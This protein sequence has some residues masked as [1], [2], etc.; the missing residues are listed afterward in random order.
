MQGPASRHVLLFESGHG[1]LPRFQIERAIWDWPGSA[2]GRAGR[3]DRQGAREEKRE[4]KAGDEES[5]PECRQEKRDT[6]QDSRGNDDRKDDEGKDDSGKDDGGYLTVLCLSLPPM[7]FAGHLDRSHHGTTSPRR[8]HRHVDRS[9]AAVGLHEVCDR[10]V[11]DSGL[12][13][14]REDAL[15]GIQ[16][17][18]VAPVEDRK[19]MRAIARDLLD[20]QPVGA[21]HGHAASLAKLDLLAR[22]LHDVVAVAEGEAEGLEPR[23]VLRHGAEQPGRPALG[24]VDCL[25]GGA[26]VPRRRAGRVVWTRAEDRSRRQQRGDEYGNEQGPPRPPKASLMLHMM[27]VCINIDV[28][29]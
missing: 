6:K 13:R 7:R 16:D 3:V 27:L 12:G 10:V 15:L 28:R 11:E 29:S 2:S 1:N 9:A 26:R 18:Y 24:L 25:A 4:C 8:R 21:D 22:R 20:A 14:L 5:R 19:V 17:G 23:K